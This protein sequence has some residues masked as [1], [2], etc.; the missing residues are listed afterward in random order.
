MNSVEEKFVRM[1]KVLN[2]ELPDRLPRCDSA[3]PDFCNVHYRRGVYSMGEPEEVEAGQ[4]KYSADGKR[5]YTHDGGLWGIGDREIYKD[6][7]DVLGVDINKFEVERIGPK[8]LAEMKR[9]YSEATQTGFPIPWHYSTAVTRATIEFGWEPFLLAAAVG[10][11]RFGEICAR[12]GEA[13]LAVA[14][15]WMEIEGVE[16]IV[17]H[18]DIAAT[19]GLILSPDWY[20]RYIFP[21][22]GKIYDAI[23]EAGR[24]AL[25]ICDGNY[26]EVLDD[27][28]ELGVDGLY[29]ESTSMDPAE[30]MRRAGPDKLY[31]VKSNTRNIDWGGPEDVRG[32]ILKLR[33]LHRDYPGMMMYRGG[34]RRAECV[35]AFEKYYQEYL[36]YV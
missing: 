28:L 25:Y 1:R 31:M 5:A 13:S 26:M 10:P 22:H 23:H 18:D 14:A 33:D 36:V 21:L 27:I 32:E 6:E 20:R 24:K 8:M 3:Q 15:G 19:R 2:L 29:I 12:F 4:V 11:D 7:T 34:G 30:F 9:L 35:E 16:L 17:I